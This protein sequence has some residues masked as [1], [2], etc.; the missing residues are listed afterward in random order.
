MRALIR[1]LNSG[2]FYS[3]DWQWTDRQEKA[4]DFGTTFQALTF[5]KENHLRDVEVLLRFGEPEYDLAVSLEL[6]VGRNLSQR[7]QQSDFDY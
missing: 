1:H 3:G 7:L 2:M 4:C 6:K 5:A